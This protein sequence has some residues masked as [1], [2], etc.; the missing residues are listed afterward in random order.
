MNVPRKLRTKCVHECVQVGA[1]FRV[2]EGHSCSV[3]MHSVHTPLDKVTTSVCT[4]T[5]QSTREEFL[6]T[7][8]STP[9][10][11]L[12]IMVTCTSCLFKSF[13]HPITHSHSTQPPLSLSLRLP[14]LDLSPPLPYPH[15]LD[16]QYLSTLCSLLPSKAH[17]PPDSPFPLQTDH[18]RLRLAAHWRS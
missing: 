14:S 16:P 4:S 6:S 17:P 8:M 12:Y 5:P 2:T 1:P 9:I 11:R 3:R 15:P 13:P 10:A 7:P 18:Q